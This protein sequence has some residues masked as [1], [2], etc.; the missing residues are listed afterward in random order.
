MEVKRLTSKR[1][2]PNTD[3]YTAAE[4]MATPSKLG[5]HTSFNTQPTD[6]MEEEQMQRESMET[7]L[8]EIMLRLKYYISNTKSG[9][10]IGARY[11]AISREAEPITRQRYPQFL[12]YSDVLDI[13]MM[14]GDLDTTTEKNHESVFFTMLMGWKAKEDSIEMNVRRGGKRTSKADESEDAPSAAQ[15][16][17]ATA[18]LRVLKEKKK[19][20]KWE[21]M[22]KAS[23]KHFT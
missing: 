4:V 10:N 23:G 17:K 5:T 7:A 6:E 18:I 16:K 1:I 9:K 2:Y 21:R 13:F 11:Y 15:I 3:F 8:D 20:E 22:A 14:V 12:F 19:E